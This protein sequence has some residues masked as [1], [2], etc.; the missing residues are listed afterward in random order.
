MALRR[1]QM[2]PPPTVVDQIFRGQ[3]FFAANQADNMEA[4]AAQQRQHVGRYARRSNVLTRRSC[5][6][7][8]CFSSHGLNLPCFQP[9]PPLQILLPNT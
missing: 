1:R 3:S 7:M 8:L 5:T 4:L 2:Q 6:P 9:F